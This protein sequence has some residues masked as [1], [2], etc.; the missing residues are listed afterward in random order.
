VPVHRGGV[1]ERLV[2]D[3]DRL[4]LLVWGQVLVAEDQDLVVGERL[5]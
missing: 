3:P 5:S 1:A 2:E 4:N